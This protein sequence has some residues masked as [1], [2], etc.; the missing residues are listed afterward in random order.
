MTFDDYQESTMKTAVY[1]D[2]ISD[3]LEP[4][5]SALGEHDIGEPTYEALHTIQSTLRRD[6]V[7]LGLGEA[8]EFQNK[9][10]KVL[11]DGKGLL[12]DESRKKM[13]E[14]LGGLLWY[15]AQCAS[16]LG[17]SLDEI[18]EENIR[19]LKSR[20]ER[21]VLQGSGDNR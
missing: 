21:G 15:V 20:K 18:A 6:Y 17:L 10:K 9:L 5:V 8:G 1:R 14:E 11:R 13:G 3:L 4:I 7:G 2:T 19:I 12:T 16:E